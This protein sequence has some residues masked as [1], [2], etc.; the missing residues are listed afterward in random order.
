M[1]ET[2]FALGFLPHRLWGNIPY[3]HL[4]VKHPDQEFYQPRETVVKSEISESY[5]RLSPMQ[6]EIV[7]LLDE[8]SDQKLHRMFSKKKSVKEFQDTVTREF[9]AE[10]IRPY[11]EKIIYKVLQIAAENRILL[12]QKEK[13]NR[14]IFSDDFLTIH[15]LP[16]TPVF[17]FTRTEAESRY[18]LTLHHQDSPLEIYQRPAEVICNFPAVIM[19]GN[20]LYFVDEIESTKIRPFFSREHVLIPKSSEKKYFSTFVRNVLR[21]FSVVPE[22]FRVQEIMPE[23]RAM[24]SLEKGLE[25]YPV[26]VIRL[27]YGKYEFFP[28]SRQQ[29]FVDFSDKND[30][31]LFQCFSRDASW[32]EALEETLTEVGLKQKDKNNFILKKTLNES[33]E[34]SVYENINF[35]NE[36]SETLQDYDITVVQRLGKSYFTGKIEISVSVEET[37]DWF[38]LFGEVVFG[39]FSF[40]FIRLRKNILNGEREYPL[41]D[42]TIAILPAEW[43]ARYREVFEFGRKEGERFYIQRQ[44]FTVIERMMDTAPGVIPESL[45][46]LNLKS[47]LPEVHQPAGLRAEL[48]RYQLEGY[49]WLWYLHKNGFGGCLADDMGLGK[50]LQAIAVLLKSR[51]DLVR[52]PSSASPGNAQL[53][54][55]GEKESTGPASLVVVPASLMHN[56]KNELLK[57]APSLKIYLHAGMNRMR[58]TGIFSG[59]DLVISTY[60][61]VRQDI[62]FLSEYYFNYIILDESQT[63]KNPASKLYRAVDMLVASHRLVLTGTPIENSLTD[64][65]SQM[66]FINEGLLGSLS[67]FKRQFVVPIERKNDKAR[68][69]RLRELISPFILRRTKEEVAPELPPVLDQVIYCS[70]TEDQKR[71]YEE[72]RSSIRNSILENLDQVE[73]DQGALMVLQALTRL[74]QLSNHPRLVNDDYPADSGKFNEVFRNIESVLAEGHKVLVFSAFVM[75]LELFREVLEERNSSYAM[76][77]GSTTNREEVVNQFQQDD[78]CRVFLI[79]LKAGGVGLNLTAADYVFILDPWWNPAAEIQALSRA[80]RIGQD[81]NVFVYRFISSDTIE[82][83]IQLL[84]ERKSAL[85]ENFISSHNPLKNISK[86][87]IIELFS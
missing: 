66:N 79:S 11:I 34:D 73:G 32:E 21:D 58:S 43:F 81:K 53:S 28:S 29:R 44:H 15:R 33:I 68:E 40:P 56:W 50:T 46:K 75:H 4:L 45:E 71:L 22:G 24:L 14:N 64:L 67:Y 19:I 49:S 13:G 86:E 70:M 10:N 76:L 18:R 35:L 59:Y 52:D 6:T 63:I 9:I 72:E 12:F 80:H 31:Y 23:K 26:W 57:Y 61:T 84:Q 30:E 54:L 55:F 78:K 25:G 2:L 38:D 83:K 77:T 41:P 65:W 1:R 17:H 74:R 42:G 82:E 8:F 85:A 87:E 69:E 51:E 5:R 3:A 16:A 39:D 27:K 47:A 7:R 20:D 60:H 48:R 62:E 37:N 36:I